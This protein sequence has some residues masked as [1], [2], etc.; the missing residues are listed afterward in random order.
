MTVDKIQSEQHTKHLRVRL[1]VLS[2]ICVVLL[3]FFIG[4]FVRSRIITNNLE[5]GLKAYEEK[6][7]SEA[8]SFFRKAALFG[9]TEAQFMLGECYHNG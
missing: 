4:S 7:Y 1:V 2:V 3:V 5:C 6:R 9:A 8:V